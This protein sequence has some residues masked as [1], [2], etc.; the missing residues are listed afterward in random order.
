MTTIPSTTM[1]EAPSLVLA[2]FAGLV[3]G[4]MFFGGLWWTV[5][6]IAEPSASAFGFL[7]SLLL[8]MA[9]VLGGVYWVG[10]GDWRRLCACLV[11]FLAAR[12]LASRL[13]RAQLA[14]APIEAARGRFGR[15]RP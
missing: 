6:R 13:V 11:G 12:I 7:G 3:L 15:G 2:L 9:V 10:D 4:A 1:I 5:R 8:R 14:A